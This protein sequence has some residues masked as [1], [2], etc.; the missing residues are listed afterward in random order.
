MAIFEIPIHKTT[1]IIDVTFHDGMKV[2]ALAVEASFERGI[3]ANLHTRCG[4]ACGTI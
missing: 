4:R 1:L 2:D 3:A